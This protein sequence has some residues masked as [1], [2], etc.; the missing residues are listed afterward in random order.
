MPHS[1]L[2][3]MTVA[4]AA[5]IVSTLAVAT[6]AFA[7]T[8]GTTPPTAP[9]LDYA[10]GFQCGSLIVGMLPS[11][12]PVTPQS[13]L[14]YEVFD[15]GTP[16][17]PAIDMGDGSGV[18]A[19]FQNDVLTPGPTNTITAK[20]EDADGNWSAPSNADVVTGYAC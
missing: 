16:I 19:W 3:R 7:T 20:A 1:R 12:S 8:G 6:T 9:V 13:Q 10:E 15:N 18:W 2:I 14:R 4:V 5:T 11:T 17:G